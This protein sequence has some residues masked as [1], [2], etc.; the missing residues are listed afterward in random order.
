MKIKGLSYIYT[1]K[2][3]TGKFKAIF[4]WFMHQWSILLQIHLQ[5]R[6][7]LSNRY[8]FFFPLKSSQHL[9]FLSPQVKNSDRRAFYRRSHRSPLKHRCLIFHSSYLLLLSEVPGN[10]TIDERKTLFPLLS[11]CLYHTMAF[12]KIFM[13]A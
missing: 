4:C 7:I 5:P 1:R 8:Y 10:F 11:K 9:P 2:V 12:K 3:L 6:S 13:G